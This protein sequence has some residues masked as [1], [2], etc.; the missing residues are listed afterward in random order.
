MNVPNL[1]RVRIFKALAHPVR[2]QILEFLRE[3]PLTVTE[4]TTRTSV[5]ISSVSKHLTQMRNAGIL[6]VDRKGLF[7]HYRL[8]CECFANLLSCADEFIRKD[9][10]K[11]HQS[12]PTLSEV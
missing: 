11:P 8:T 4:I 7:Q 12:V 6:E 5:S 2:I 3:G 10:K 1:H 9:F